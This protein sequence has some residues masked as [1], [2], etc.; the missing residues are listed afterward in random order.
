MSSPPNPYRIPKPK[1]GILW[2]GRLFTSDK[3]GRHKTA[4]SNDC[5]AVL[6]STHLWLWRELAIP[7][8]S[9]KNILSFTEGAVLRIAFHQALIHQDLVVYLSARDFFSRRDKQK[10]ATLQTALQEAWQTACEQTGVQDFQA[11]MAALVSDVR[12]ETC[13][14]PHAAL[15]ESGYHFSLSLAPFFWGHDYWT[16]FRPYVCQR[17]AILTTCRNNF[18][19][20]LIG[21]LGFPAIFTG[22][23]HVWQNTRRLQKL[24]PIGPVTALATLLTGF[25]VPLLVLISLW[26]W[27]TAPGP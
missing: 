2:S 9:I 27:F 19:T 18:I 22:P 20:S 11:A 4:G 14:S 16:T 6:T 17:H 5:P 15:L 7:L 1:T 24:F 26:L 3:K 23:Y 10:L 21:Y 13:G 12:C 8:V 25:L